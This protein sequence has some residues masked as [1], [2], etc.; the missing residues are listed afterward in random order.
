MFEWIRSW[1][2]TFQLWRTDRETY[3]F[4]VNYRLD[5]DDLVEA[6]RPGSEA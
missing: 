4:L 3:N 2:I 1:W 6:S 5:P